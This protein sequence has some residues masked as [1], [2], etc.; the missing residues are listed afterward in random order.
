MICICVGSAQNGNSA[1][2]LQKPT[3]ASSSTSPS[4]SPTTRRRS[5]GV[6]AAT[7][8][9]TACSTATATSGCSEEANADQCQP[10]TG[11]AVQEM[12]AMDCPVAECSI[13]LT[14]TCLEGILAPFFAIFL[15]IIDRFER[16]T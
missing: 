3:S 14:W 5:A 6:A 13:P 11:V 15:P 4:S 10:G 7:A 9:A 8:A 1:D 12:P 2:L 16:R